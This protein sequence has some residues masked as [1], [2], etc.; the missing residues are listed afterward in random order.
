MVY[1]ITWFIRRL[2]YFTINPEMHFYGYLGKP[3]CILGFNSIRLK[4]KTRIFPG[5]RLECHDDGSSITIEENTSI[6]QNFH[7]TSGG[8]LVIGRDT[9]ISGNVCITNIDHDYSEIGM[10]VLNQKHIINE[11][12]IGSNCFIGF[13]AVIQAGT[14]LGDQCIVGANSV[15]RGV[16]PPFSIIVGAPAKIVKKYSPENDDWSRV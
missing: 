14:I 11:T 16:F 7:C 6:G 9:V 4:R 8:S 15:V 12:E 5:A 3:I 13:G 2:I 10:P 1:K